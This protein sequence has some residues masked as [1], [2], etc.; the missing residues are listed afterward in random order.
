MHVAEAHRGPEAQLEA[1][2][3]GHSHA[4]FG[5]SAHDYLPA[6]AIDVFFQPFGVYA[7]PEEKLRALAKRLPPDLKWGGEWSLAV[8]GC[9][10]D[11]P[12]FQ[13]RDWPT[14]ACNFPKGNA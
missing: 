7:L 9:G 4:A 8:N 5:H 10:P 3:T 11:M 13:V 2:E 1:V 14:L 6:L 12:H